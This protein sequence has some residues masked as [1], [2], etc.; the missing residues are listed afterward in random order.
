MNLRRLTPCLLLL[1]VA[2]AAPAQNPGDD[3]HAVESKLIALE[4][5]WNQAQLHRDTGALEALLAANFSNTEWDGEVTNRAQFLEDIRNPRYK[6]SLS[7]IQDLKVAL[8][9]NMAI[10]TGTYHTKGTSEGKPYE[11]FGRFTDTWTF[12]SG[13]WQCVASHTSLLK[14]DTE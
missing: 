7:T 5:I 1:F 2:I 9:G 11:H 12:D 4:N 14:K 10:L 3:Q 8:Y 13:H 6:P